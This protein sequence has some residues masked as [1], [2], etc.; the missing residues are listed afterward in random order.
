MFYVKERI[1]KKNCIFKIDTGSD[2][3]LIRKGLLEIN[4][5]NSK[6]LVTDRLILGI[7]SVK[8]FR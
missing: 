1:N 3:T 4:S 7:L 2:V 6:F 5:L 8:K